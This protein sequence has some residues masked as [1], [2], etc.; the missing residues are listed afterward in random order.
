MS[1]PWTFSLRQLDW[2]AWKKQSVAW[3]H[4]SAL[5]AAIGRSQGA[6]WNPSDF[7]PLKQAERAAKKAPITV[8]RDIFVDRNMRKVVAEYGS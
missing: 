2:M 5:A 6:K 8:L 1:D 7:H 4:T 3:D